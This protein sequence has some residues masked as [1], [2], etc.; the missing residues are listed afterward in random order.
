VGEHIHVI[1]TG[2]EDLFDARVEVGSRLS[3]DKERLDEGPSVVAVGL[4]PA[5]VCRDRGL[6]TALRSFEAFIVIPPLPAE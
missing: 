4:L 6:K 3:G 5:F 2:V 1:F